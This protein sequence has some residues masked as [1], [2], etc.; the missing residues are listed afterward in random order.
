VFERI[1]S[2]LS[3]NSCSKFG[4]QPKTT[5]LA[6]SFNG[7]GYAPI[8]QTPEIHLS[9]NQRV[10]V[11]FVASISNQGSIRFMLYTSTLNEAIFLV[12]L[13]RLIAKRERKL[14]WIVDQHPVHRGK[15]VQQWLAEHSEQIE[16]FFLPSY[17]PQLNRVSQW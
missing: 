7:R 1:R 15:L 2:G 11:N 6:A 4:C 10:R 14:F 9:E 16:L 12:F 17:S 13:K 3:R 8:G 5:T